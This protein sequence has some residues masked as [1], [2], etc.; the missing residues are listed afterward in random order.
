MVFKIMKAK[1]VFFFILITFISSCN[2]NK[3]KSPDV[4]NIKV[5]VE[6]ERYEQLLFALD[7]LHFEESVK[8]LQSHDSLF[9]QTY[10]E[11]ILEL[12]STR[13][14]NEPR[15]AI[16]L[17]N[18]ITNKAVRGLNDTVQQHYNDIT[19]IK[20]EMTKVYQ[21]YSYYFPN[22]PLPKIYTIISEFGYGAA[23]SDN[24]LA[25]GLDMFLGENYVFYPAQDFPIYF[26]KKLKKEYLIANAAKA[27][28]NDKIAPPKNNAMLDIMLY[29]GKQMFL[30]KK[31]IP[32]LPDT[33]L[34]GFTSKQ[35]QWCN[36]NESEIWKFFIAQ[37]LLYNTKMLDYR[38]YVSESP[39]APGMPED[40]PGNVGSY[41]GYKIIEKL[42]ENNSDITLTQLLQMNDATRI[43]QLSKY[44]P[45]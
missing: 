29:N 4:S 40:A 1:L 8:K 37:K 16:P 26:I 33:I 30:T 36:E 43:L 41:I 28:G 27:L 3:N 9:F 13:N 23:K 6:I 5:K 22:E 31:M 14:P 34:S 19:F 10:I 24:A 11:D 7:T 25:I 18:F 32:S 42:Y 45:K 15:F 20:N 17:Y 38:K 39:N 21:Y 44:K 12:G 35:Q 2:C